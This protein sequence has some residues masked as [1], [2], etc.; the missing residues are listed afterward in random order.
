MG[1]DKYQITLRLHMGQTC[2]GFHPATSPESTD[3][4]TNHL[5][6]ELQWPD[7]ECLRRADRLAIE[8]GTKL[9]SI[10]QDMFVDHASMIHAPGED[11]KR[12]K[13]SAT[14]SWDPD[15]VLWFFLMVAGA[16]YGGIHLL[17]WNGPFQTAQEQW[18]WRISGII[19]ASPVVI[20]T[21]LYNA[22]AVLW[23]WHDDWPESKLKTRAGKV[24]DVALGMAILVF[25]LVYSAAR[26]YVVVECFMNLAHLPPEVYQEPSWSRYIPHFSAG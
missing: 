15:N 2:F 18:L 11:L 9:D 23:S 5:Y 3:D 6:A 26:V 1:D 21:A 13:R 16:I 25:G 12:F 4:N 14:S 22:I 24:G 8:E 17:A 20:V 19:I 7:I 10:W